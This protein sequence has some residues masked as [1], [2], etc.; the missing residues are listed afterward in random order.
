MVYDAIVIGLGAMGSATLHALA[1]RGISAIG[2][3][4]FS[5]PHTL[6]STHGKSRII[7]EA[8]FEDPCY[9][10]LLQRAYVCWAQIEGE[11]GEK[12][13]LKTGGLMIGPEDGILVAGSRRSAEHHHLSHEMLTTRDVRNRYPGLHP[14]DEMIALYEPRAGVLFPER[15][16]RACLDL[17]VRKGAV[18]KL[19]ERVVSWS[20]DGG[21][22]RVNTTHNSYS[23]AR[24]VI[25]AGPWIARLLP[26]LPLHLNVE[27]QLFHW[28]RPAERPEWFAHSACP[29]ALWEHEPGRIF[30]TFP[31]VAG[32]GVK[33]GVHHEGEITNAD[34]VRRDTTAQ[35][36]RSVRELLA[37]FMPAAVGKLLDA[38]VCLYTNTPDHHFLID[39]HPAHHEV[40]IAS[41][42][43]GHG[44]KFASALG[45]VLADLVTAGR[46]QLDISRF[47]LGI[48]D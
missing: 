46:S 17:A 4:Q 13:F 37:R 9:V 23:A 33:I 48:R 44:F 22:V 42:C 20:A 38:S 36:D 25:A 3:D 41:P 34:T 2:I 30:A 35:E 29:V 6:G 28:F 14:T 45:E 27:R 40:I 1:S 43:S 7:R 32:Q 15:S 39:T 19:E 24:L 11:S 31:D 12:L 8:Y 26:E 21:S 16:V 47:R 10:P 5:P 18:T